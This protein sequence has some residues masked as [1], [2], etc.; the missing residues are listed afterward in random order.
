M[1]DD[2]EKGEV[3]VSELTVIIKDSEKTLRTKHLI[4]ELYTVNQHDPIIKN[5][6]AEA[7]MDFG[8]QPESIKVRI[9]LTVE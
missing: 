7:V 6:I 5:L 9:N 4:Y 1:Q 8:A 3:M 2:E